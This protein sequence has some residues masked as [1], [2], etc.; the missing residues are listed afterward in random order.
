[1]NNNPTVLINQ[2]KQIIKQQLSRIYLQTQITTSLW[3]RNASLRFRNV[4]LH[5]QYRAL[6]VRN[7]KAEPF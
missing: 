1:M 4:P 3:I 5:L 7:G 2:F 6:R